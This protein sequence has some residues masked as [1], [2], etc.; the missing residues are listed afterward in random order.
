ME[1]ILGKLKTL[2]FL[3]IPLIFLFLL[4]FQQAIVST[5]KI[6]TS[7]EFYENGAAFLVVMAIFI[8]IVFRNRHNLQI[9]SGTRVVPFISLLVVLFL[10]TVNTLY[11]KFSIVPSMFFLLGIYCLLGFYLEYRFWKRSLFIFLIL[12]LTLPLLE[13]VQKFLGFP[14]RLA[15]ANIVSFLLG[16][17]GIGNISKSA[18]I[19]TENHA[20]SIDLPCSGVK[21]IYTGALFMLRGLT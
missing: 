18:V 1:A 19:V 4:Y 11:L 14:I 3:D 17:F 6:F 12:I 10:N 16:F 15:T 21:S 2:N 5:W 20:T 7:K 13:R 9:S 8:S